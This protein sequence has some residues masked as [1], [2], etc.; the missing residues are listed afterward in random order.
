MP[1]VT[2]CK[3]LMA[4]VLRYGRFHVREN[5]PGS[6]EV[7]ITYDTVITGLSHHYGTAASMEGRGGSVTDGVMLQLWAYR[8]EEKWYKVG[9]QEDMYIKS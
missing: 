3:K 6:S 4:G 5:V 1:G 7:K 9:G 2:P 8:Q